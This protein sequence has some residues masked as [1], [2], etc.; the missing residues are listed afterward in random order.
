[1]TDTA[2]IATTVNPWLHP[3]AGGEPPPLTERLVR[4]LEAHA[5]ASTADSSSRRSLL[6]SRGGWRISAAP[7]TVS[8]MR[9][10]K[11]RPMF[12]IYFNS[13]I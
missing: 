5:A 1:M 13:Y 12:L 8:Q 6:S 4:A 7:A 11:F 9:Q 3:L 10:L 2:P